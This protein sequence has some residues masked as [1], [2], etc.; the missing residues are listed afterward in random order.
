MLNLLRP[1][2]VLSTCL[3][4]TACGWWRDVPVDNRPASVIK[5][6]FCNANPAWDG[7]NCAQDPRHAEAPLPARPPKPRAV[8]VDTVEDVDA[9]IA[10]LL[11]EPD[12]GRARGGVR[13]APAADDDM[14]VTEVPASPQPATSPDEADV[15]SDSTRIDDSPGD[16][17]A[18]QLV[19]MSSRTGAEAFIAR[20]GLSDV[21]LTPVES[22]GRVYTALIY[23]IYPNRDAA[24]AAVNARPASLQHIQPWI[25]RFDSLQAATA[26]ASG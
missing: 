26:R 19:A 15:V 6:W 23:G 8:A 14:P 5:T 3:S 18:V 13:T 1:A 12:A 24:L 17:Y 2:L 20:H 7:W 22:A 4:L 16:Y 25:R 11:T 9:V 21:T 10:R